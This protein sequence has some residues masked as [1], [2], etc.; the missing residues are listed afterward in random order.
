MS[1]K[2]K[3][4]IDEEF[5]SRLVRVLKTIKRRQSDGTTNQVQQAYYVRQASPGDRYASQPA[6][7]FEP[8]AQGMPQ[9]ALPVPDEDPSSYMPQGGQLPVEPA[10]PPPKSIVVKSHEIPWLVGQ[11]EDPDPIPPEVRRRFDGNPINRVVKP[12]FSSAPMNSVASGEALMW[13]A[14]EPDVMDRLRAGRIV[15]IRSS[16]AE[17]GVMFVK[18]EHT[19]GTRYRAYLRM[20]G[21]NDPFTYEAWGESYALDRTN[22]DLSRRA[23]A[24]YEISK[25]TGLDDLVPPTGVRMDEYGDLDP[26]LSD[27]LIE[28]ADYYAESIARVTGENPG[29]LRRKL[30]GFGAVQLFV[31]ETSG[32]ESQEWFRG[33][34]GGSTDALNRVFE[35]MPPQIRAAMLRG[36]VLD[37]ILWTGDRTIA[38]LMFCPNDK[39]PVHFINNDLSLPHP[40]LMAAAQTQHGRTFIEAHTQELDCPPMLWSDVALMVA[41][42]GQEAE[43]DDYERIGIESAKRLGIERAIDLT[44]CL[45][46][47][48][49]P[50][51]HIAG[52]LLRTRLLRTNSRDI[53]RNPYI[54]SQ[55]LVEA[56]TGVQDG[57]L[58]QFPGVFDYVNGIM[59][60]ATHKDYDFVSELMSEND[61]EE[62]EDDS[63]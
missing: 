21:L 45:M 32:I 7:Q 16:G 2:G 29:L 41:L 42:R 5:P 20:E 62:G 35:I 53:M 36:A 43:E 48:Q 27:E 63:D 17:N 9:D 13:G 44:R 3:D 19:D 1:L 25:A 4:K 57:L 26:I 50:E 37:Y 34:F 33:I 60:K 49:I 15:S 12:T 51:L 58:F 39:H 59:S 56:M 40:G 18:L 61:G 46:E 11:E 54:A 47:H 30:K 23:S 10:A 6:Q 8:Q 55:L 22:G 24:A 28:R 38:D 14:H 31:E 52:M